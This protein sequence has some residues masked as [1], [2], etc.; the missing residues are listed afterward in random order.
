MKGVIEIAESDPDATA[1]TASPL[2]APLLE[3][4]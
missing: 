4:F 3:S 2:A 1:A